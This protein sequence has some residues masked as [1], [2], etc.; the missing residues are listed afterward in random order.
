MPLHSTYAV[1]DVKGTKREREQLSRDVRSH[2]TPPIKVLIEGELDQPM[3]DDGISQEYSV[4]VTSA[5][6]TS[7]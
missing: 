4:R 7:T 1:L 3:R 5:K 6:I 2:H